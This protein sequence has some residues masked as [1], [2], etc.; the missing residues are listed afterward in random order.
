MG[1]RIKQSHVGGWT[2]SCGMR[3]SWSQSAHLIIL[4]WQKWCYFEFG[5]SGIGGGGKEPTHL[6]IGLDS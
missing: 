5:I 6:V 2:L 1:L 4:L 3:R